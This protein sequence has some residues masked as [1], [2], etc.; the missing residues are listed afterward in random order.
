MGWNDARIWKV[1]T[2]ADREKERIC[3]HAVYD[4][5]GRLLLKIS[6]L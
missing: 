5:I 1:T 6:P 3:T 4:K 2:P